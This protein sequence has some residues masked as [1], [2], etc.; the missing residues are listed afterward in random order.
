MK[1]MIYETFSPDEALRLAKKI[2]IHHTPKHGSWLNMAEIEIGVMS[3]QCLKGYLS[4]IETAS[5]KVS[6]WCEDRNRKNLSVNWQFTT[7]E[8]RIKLKSLYPVMARQKILCKRSSTKSRMARNQ[9][10]YVGQIPLDQPSP[11]R[12]DGMRAACGVNA[13]QISR[14]YYFKGDQPAFLSENMISN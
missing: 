13:I 2:E 5:R 6:A 9:R 7:S 8:A 1:E 12:M 3:R 4:N 10:A 11:V 14:E